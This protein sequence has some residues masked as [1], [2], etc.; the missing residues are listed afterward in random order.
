MICD[1]WGVGARFGIVPV[2][3][4]TVYWAGGDAITKEHREDTA[5]D[6]EHSFGTSDGWPAPVRDIVSP[7]SNLNAKRVV[8]YDHEPVSVW[9]NRCVLMIGDAVLPP[10][11]KARQ[12][13]SRTRG[14]CSK[15][16]FNRRKP[17]NL[18]WC[19]SRR[20]AEKRRKALRW[21]HVHLPHQYSSPMRMKVN[22]ETV[23]P[24]KPTIHRW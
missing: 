1:Y 12:R 21:R 19:V 2:S 23:Q 16:W 18:C 22:S 20:D 14:V 5:E 17:W 9:H 13:R 10:L 3:N 8:L 11:D 4:D 15:R 24:L 6:I 7:T